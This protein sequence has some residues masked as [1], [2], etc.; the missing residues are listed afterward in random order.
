M[1][2]AA[3]AVDRDS[4]TR[5]AEPAA[6]RR[7]YRVRLRERSAGLS[8]PSTSE[9]RRRRHHHRRE[10]E[11]GAPEKRRQRRH[12]S[13]E[14][15]LAT[16]REVDEPVGGTP[17]RRERRRKHHHRRK[18]GLRLQEM[19][20]AATSAQ[21]VAAAPGTEQ[22]W[23][24]RGLDF[25]DPR[26]R[27]AVQYGELHVERAERRA[28]AAATAVWR[29]RE[30]EP[31]PAK[32]GRRPFTQPSRAFTPPSGERRMAEM[33]GRGAAAGV[34]TTP[35]AYDRVAT[36][37]AAALG[38]PL[39]GQQLGWPEG[40]Q[41]GGADGSEGRALLGPCSPTE[42][43]AVGRALR[44]HWLG[45]SV[46]SLP[47]QG[48]S[49]RS[50]GL[51]L[52][53]TGGSS[54]SVL[55]VLQGFGG[56]PLG[57][58]SSSADLRSFKQA[59][60]DCEAVLAAARRSRRR[61]QALALAPASPLT[62]AA[63]ASPLTS[64]VAAAASPSGGRALLQSRQP[65][66]APTAAASAEAEA[67]SMEDAGC[68]VCFEQYATDTLIAYRGDCGH[69]LCHQCLEQLVVACCPFCRLPW[70]EPAT[71]HEIANGSYWPF[72]TPEWFG[73]T[74]A[75]RI[76][77]PLPDGSGRYVNVRPPAGTRPGMSLCT[78]FRVWPAHAR[79]H[80]KPGARGGAN[81][82]AAARARIAMRIA[83]EA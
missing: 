63:T 55:R 75:T 45:R 43:A 12:R 21:Q 61:E 14:V 39:A 79:G 19:A 20:I 9:G 65:P 23:T 25:G 15:P 80:S 40:I 66:G 36:L 42:S 72:I 6:S 1:A 76:R 64:A 38:S 4:Q 56:R 53:L 70:A 60:I 74:A 35:V 13:R 24:P 3:A 59:A 33:A 2:M 10:G 34:Q 52:P 67:V 50:S 47:M 5:P 18:H 51:A 57:A 82:R 28:S 26:A 62:A 73:Q 68:A 44:T 37:G 83:I 54:G 48:S 7:R 27:E 78:T 31:E 49:L 8:E 32:V 81:C 17:A 46:D 16:V 11:G 29:T 22:V 71:L 41:G 58:S 77:L 30:P 69:Q